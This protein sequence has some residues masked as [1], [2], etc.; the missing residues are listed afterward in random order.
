MAALCVAAALVVVPSALGAFTTAKLEVRQAAAVTTFKT[1]QSADDDAIASVRIFVPSGTSLTTTQ[2]PG[3]VLGNV[4]AVVKAL[5]LG[6]ASVPFVGQLVV[7]P[8]GAVSAAVTQACVGT[9]VTPLATWLMNLTAAGQNVPVPTFLVPTVGALTALGPAYI[10]VCL[11]SPYIPSDQ[12]GAIFGAQLV[13]AEFS[14]QGVFGRVAVGAFVAIWTPYAQGTGT[15]NAAATVATPAAVAAGAVTIAAKRLGQGALV[16]GRVTQA[17]Q[18]R[19]GATVTIRGGARPSSLKKLGSVKVRANG[20][21]S[22]RA[23][24]GT[25]FKGSA[26]ATTA[27][28]APLCTALGPAI[29]PIPCV[30][31]TVNGFAVQSKTVKKK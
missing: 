15:V 1:S 30:N 7:A 8:P 10:Q 6:G 3:T 16:T 20:S 22:F 2:A 19:G 29:A 27:A 24:T 23:K 5:A 14:A 13:S 28:A 31:P 9:G 25:F 4:N 21:Y 17:G 18:A 12:G 26:V 11:P